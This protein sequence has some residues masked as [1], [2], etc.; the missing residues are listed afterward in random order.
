MSKK[1]NWRYLRRVSQF[2]VIAL[3]FYLTL[4]HLNL[5]IEKA[6]PI[7]AYCPLGGLESLLTYI[8]T[9]A[10]LNRIL[11]SSFTLLV[12]VIIFTIFFGRVFCGYCCCGFS[13]AG[14]AKN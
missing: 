11:L 8:T 6:A 4:K 3:V 7:D 13:L 10:F 14:M 1:I 5:G 12:I 2:A 9:G